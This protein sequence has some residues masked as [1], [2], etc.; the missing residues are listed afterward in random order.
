MLG[1]LTGV[2][3]LRNNLG[4]QFGEVGQILAEEAGL[5]NNSLPGVRGGQ[6]ATK[7]L[8]LASDAKS[9]PSLGVLH[10]TRQISSSPAFGYRV[11]SP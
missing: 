3:G 9:R 1:S 8:R 10:G 6:L 5:K 7:Q 2:L 11:S 4:Q